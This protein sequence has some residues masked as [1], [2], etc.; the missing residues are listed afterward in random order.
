MPLNSLASIR[1]PIGRRAVKP[2]RRAFTLWELMLTAA[3][4]VALMAFSWPAIV[5]PLA[6]MRLRKAADHVQAQFTAARTQATL[7][8]TIHVF[9]YDPS[10]RSYSIQPW[11]GVSV[12][13]DR[14][15]TPDRNSPSGTTGTSDVQ[16]TLPEGVSIVSASAS[17]GTPAPTSAVTTAGAANTSAGEF[18]I[19]FYPDGTTTDAIVILQNDE[20]LT[21]TVSLRGLT[22]SCRVSQPATASETSKLK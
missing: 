3:L 9:R 11:N 1:S 15:D 14:R 19:L 6:R 7:S 17:S 4:L 13:Q 12:E 2:G 10:T 20:I 21:I 8:G 22:G 16:Q 18:P 5:G